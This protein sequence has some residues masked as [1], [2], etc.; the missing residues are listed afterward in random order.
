MVCIDWQVPHR[1]LLGYRMSTL[2]VLQWFFPLHIFI[3]RNW[4]QVPEIIPHV[5]WDA[6]EAEWLE[7]SFDCCGLMCVDWW[8]IMK[9]NTWHKTQLS[10]P[11]PPWERGK[12][13]TNTKNRRDWF[14]ILKSLASLILSGK[15]G[16]KK[17]EDTVCEFLTNSLIQRIL[18]QVCQREILLQREMVIFYVCLV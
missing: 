8:N 17:D 12:K 16:G 9:K 11:P 6:P 15:R 5:V 10:F 4:I 18:C 3:S 1:I 14:N 7:W 13:K 2:G